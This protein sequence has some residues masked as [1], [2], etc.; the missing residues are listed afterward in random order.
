MSVNP[1]IEADDAYFKGLI[2]Y[3]PPQFYFDKETR[4]DLAERRSQ[5]LEEKFKDQ[6]KNKRNGSVLSD[7][8]K[9]KR[10][11]FDPQHQRTVSQ[12]KEMML[13]NKTLTH[14]KSDV[15]ESEEEPFTSVKE[16][17][18][19]NKPRKKLGKKKG[20]SESMNESN[21][22]EA[23]L[24]KLH[25]RI[26]AFK[27][28]RTLSGEEMK[29][30]KKL[31]RKESKLKLKMKRKKD[32]NQKSVQGVNGHVIATPKG[33]AAKPIFNKEGKMVFSKFDFT[34]VGDKEK[35]S[36][37][38]TGKDYKKLLEK[39]EKRKQKIQELSEKDAE[40]GKKF[41]EKVAWE[42]ALHK[43]EGVK[44]KDNP[45]H[46]KRALKKKEKMKEQRKKKWEE[47]TERTEKQ[48]HDKQVKRKKN[49]SAKK[50]SRIE[51]KIKKQK[52]KGRVIPG[53]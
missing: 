38:M 25:S 23:L 53:F 52:K 12:I 46:L 29:E 13:E 49:I 44:V 31:R 3:I 14:E 30:R 16:R 7:K 1:T 45:E 26:E 24:E 51:N 40:K 20:R 2:D 8:A 47:R 41:Q 11:K 35:S 36:N 15:S 9:I 21:T 33:A 10:L 27:S 39:V 6:G 37:P 43:A 28:K 48:L 42:T 17:K 18:K 50:Q 22:K 19:K 34:D 4:V 32:K 5:E